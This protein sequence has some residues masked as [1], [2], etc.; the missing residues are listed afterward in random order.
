LLLH[1]F[2]NEKHS[3]A[4]LMKYMKPI[5]KIKFH[6]HLLTLKWT[7]APDRNET[8]FP[9][10]SFFVLPALEFDFM[11]Y[12]WYWLGPITLVGEH[13]LEIQTYNSHGN[14]FYM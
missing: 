2:Q 13:Y 4:T 3:N 12:R 7:E 5:M 10:S 14:C 6:L 1:G 9:F 11:W 8:H